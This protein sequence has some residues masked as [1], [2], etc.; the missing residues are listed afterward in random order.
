MFF[1]FSWISSNR[2][3]TWRRY[4]YT[5]VVWLNFL[6]RRGRSWSD[7]TARDYYDFKHWR[8]T[9]SHNP[10]RV[11]AMSFDTD[12]A[13]LSSFYRW[14]SSEYGVLNPIPTRPVQD[15]PTRGQVRSRRMPDRPAGSPRRDPKWLL[16]QAFEQWRDVGLRGYEFDGRRPDHWRGF[17]EDRDAAFVDGLYGTGLRL[18]E[19]ATIL[20]VELPQPGTSGRFPRAW[21]ARECAKGGRYG[22]SYRIPRAVVKAVTGYMDPLEGSRAEAIGRAQRAGRYERLSSAQIVT[23]HNP[24]SRTVRVRTA[25]GDTWLSLNAL[26]ET[27]RLRLFRRTPAGLEPLAVWLSSNGM[28][29]QAHSWENTFR[30]ANARVADA[31]VRAGTPELTGME[32][33]RRRVLCPLWARPHMLRHSYALRWYSILSAVWDHRLDGF[34]ETEKVAFREQFGDVWFQ[35]ATLLGHRSPETTKDWYLEPFVGL[36]ID[37][38]FALLDDDDRA[39]VDSLLRKTTADSDLVLSPVRL[40]GTADYG[41]RA[42]GGVR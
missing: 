4:A 5:L 27:D 30:S 26:N 2:P 15:K 32:R 13:A 34:T 24:H 20:D 14:A 11:G 28:P 16:R 25:R 35:L 39:A 22:R 7:V 1:R 21:L 31:W 37:Y 8:M 18:T 12:R 17:N 36:E 41:R 42:R 10:N 38:I 9:D 40:E 3:R 29:R 33:D 6:E 19:W 23:G